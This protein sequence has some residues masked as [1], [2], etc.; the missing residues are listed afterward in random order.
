MSAFPSRSRMRCSSSTP[1]RGTMTCCVVFALPPAPSRT[2]RAGGRRWRPRAASCRRSRAACRSGNSARP[3]APSRNASCPSAAATPC[4]QPDGL[5]RID[6]L[7]QRKF[8]GRQRRE[9]KRL[10]PALIET[11]LAFRDQRNVV[12]SGKERRISSSFRPGTVISPALLHGDLGRRHQ[13]HLEV[14]GRDRQCARRA[15]RNSTLAST[16]MVWRRSTTPMTACR[17]ASNFSRSAVNFMACP[18]LNS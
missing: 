15:L 11:L 18:S 6:V 7:D 1:L 17:G 8:R 3:A 14:G 10:R 12:F 9:L 16:G 2:A 4:A 5:L 13:L